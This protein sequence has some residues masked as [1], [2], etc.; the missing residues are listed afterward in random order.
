MGSWANRREA[1]KRRPLEPGAGRQGVTV[2]DM[3]APKPEIERPHIKGLPG[4]TAT[5]DED[6]QPGGGTW[7]PLTTL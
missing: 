1:G 6:H 7:T 2:T 5:A 4:P 3:P